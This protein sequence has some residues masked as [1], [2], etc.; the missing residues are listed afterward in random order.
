MRDQH[1]R[2]AEEDLP[3][4]GDVA[5]FVHLH[6]DTAERMSDRPSMP[7]AYY[8][9][10]EGKPRP[11]LVLCRLPQREYGRRW[12]LVLPITSKNHGNRGMVLPISDCIESGRPSYIMCKALSR[13]P[14]NLLHRKDG[15]NWVIRTLDKLTSANLV[16]ILNHLNLGWR[17]DKA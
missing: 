15:E 1:A 16:K 4:A 14:E 9:R 5:R 17:W 3:K 2:A 11:M 7:G 6:L 8:Y 12:F 10:L 13:L